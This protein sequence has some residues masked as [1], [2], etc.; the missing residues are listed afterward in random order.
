LSHTHATN[1]TYADLSRIA[2]TTSPE[3]YLERLRPGVQD[4][5]DLS[6][7]VVTWLKT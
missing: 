6:Q 7:P 3:R 2:R 1:G 4:A 5:S